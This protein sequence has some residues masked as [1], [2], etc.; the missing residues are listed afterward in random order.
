M[1]FSRDILLS[2]KKEKFLELRQITTSQFLYI[3]RNSSGTL[4]FHGSR[5]SLSEYLLSTRDQQ[6]VL[7]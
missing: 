2:K 4:K 5:E 7:F 3:S 6:Q 1:L